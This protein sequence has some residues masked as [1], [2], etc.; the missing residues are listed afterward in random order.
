MQWSEAELEKESVNAKNKQVA[1]S[2]PPFF[3]L[4]LDCCN[5]IFDLLSLDDL[6][7]LGQ[8]CKMMQKAAG[9]YFRN[10]YRASK[11]TI[12]HNS[13]H[14]G[15]VNLIGFS[16][17]IEKFWMD[18]GI[19]DFR[20]AGAHCHNGTAKEIYFD[21]FA[22]NEAKIECIKRILANI[23]SVLLTD[24]MI[25]G[26]FYETF[27][28][29]CP[30][31]RRLSVFCYEGFQNQWLFQKYP[32][33]EY[34]KL[35]GD[36]SLQFRDIQQL[37][38][39][40]PNVQHFATDDRFLL[41]NQDSITDAQIKWHDLVVSLESNYIENV[42]DF[43]T[44]FIELHGA[45]VYQQL[46]LFLNGKRWDES[47]FDK[48][49]QVPAIVNLCLDYFCTDLNVQILND[50]KKFEVFRPLNISAQEL[51]RFAK[52]LPHLERVVFREAS[53]NEIF[54][55]I[56]FAKRL[57]EIRVCWLKCGIHFDK[58]VDLAKLNHER[59]KLSDA[60]QM[61]IY[62]E[63]RVYVATKRIMGKIRF[64]LIEMRRIS[65]YQ[66]KSFYATFV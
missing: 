20:F 9:E 49:P 4:N 45:G 59:E 57:K 52:D 23:E 6:H 7:S 12:K 62:V 51:Q 14:L 66:D 47:F 55:F 24:C 8:T 33:L 19:E 15:V 5:E 21:L 13:F 29:F 58:Y 61:I 42:N 26:D 56:C 60:R 16:E 38:A 64:S 17:F 25:P 34:L 30:K 39:N 40:N 22:L 65:S 53:S 32:T 37:F 28:R 11:V 10:N 46:H 43:S 48:L 50:L 31:L 63:E 35:A 41:A 54:P 36:V 27:L 1:T 44:L 3:T 2:M 18:G